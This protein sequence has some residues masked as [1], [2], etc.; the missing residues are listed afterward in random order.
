MEFKRAQNRAK[1][2]NKIKPNKG[3]MVSKSSQIEGEVL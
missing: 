3:Q 2:I 1:Q